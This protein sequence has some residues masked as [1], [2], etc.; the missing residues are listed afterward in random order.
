[1]A[2]PRVRLY[3]D[4]VLVWHQGEWQLAEVEDMRT[5]KVE[6]DPDF[7]WEVTGEHPF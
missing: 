1:M 5:L 6:F 7:E 3:E 4:C 2:P